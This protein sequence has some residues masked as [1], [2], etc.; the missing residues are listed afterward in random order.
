MGHCQKKRWCDG[1][2]AKLIFEKKEE[3]RV[4]GDDGIKL[5]FGDKLK[6]G[7]EKE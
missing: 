5:K 7:Y 4:C 1:D 6:E 2:D 3:E